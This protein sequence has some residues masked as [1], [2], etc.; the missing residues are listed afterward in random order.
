MNEKFE[1]ITIQFHLPP[2]QNEH[3][4]QT[5]TGKPVFSAVMEGMLRHVIPLRA[6]G[7]E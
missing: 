5:D 4:C 3:N 2:R 6:F 7:N 1:L